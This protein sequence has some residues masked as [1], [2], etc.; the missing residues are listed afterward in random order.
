M[1]AKLRLGVAS[2]PRRTRRSEQRPGPTGRAR[3]CLS[4]AQGTFGLS[5]AA[6]LNFTLNLR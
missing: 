4:G 3:S 2:A 1:A 5:D 6:V